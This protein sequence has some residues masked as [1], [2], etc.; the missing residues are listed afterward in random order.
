M[1]VLIRPGEALAGLVIGDPLDHP[2]QDTAL[3]DRTALMNATILVGEEF[4]VEKKDAYLD[5]VVLDDLSASIF[6]IV[7]APHI[8]IRHCRLLPYAALLF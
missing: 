4:T 8:N 3:A 1:D 7:L 6:E 2:V 5:I